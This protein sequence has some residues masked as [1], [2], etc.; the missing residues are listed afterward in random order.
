MD[1]DKHVKRL[2]QA[3]HL[4]RY[5]RLSLIPTRR[6]QRGN[7]K[8]RPCTAHEVSNVVFFKENLRVTGKT[9]F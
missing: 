4:E 1:I 2:C 7:G 3:L 6:V 5:K 8:D 9:S